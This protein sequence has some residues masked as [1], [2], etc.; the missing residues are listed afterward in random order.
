VLEKA[1]NILFRPVLVIAMQPR[2]RNVGRPFGAIWRAAGKTLVFDDSAKDV[3]QTVAFSTMPGPVHEIRPA[4]ILCSFC[5]IGHES[6]FAKKQQLPDAEQSAFV[7]WKREL[8]A[9]RSAL[10]QRQCFEISKKVTNVVELHIAI[11]GVRE[12]RIKIGAV[13]RGA[14]PQ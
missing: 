9:M 12:R 13:L 5:T 2:R 4:V 8:M 1:R 3:A 11:R 14:S 7:E 10:H 6:P